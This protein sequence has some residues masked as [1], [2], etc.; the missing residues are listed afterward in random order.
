LRCQV[1]PS[2]PAADQTQNIII[3]VRHSVS[4]SSDSLVACLAGPDSHRVSLDGRLSA[5]GAHVFGVL[6]DLHLLYLFSKGGTVS[7]NRQI[8]QSAMRSNSFFKL[9]RVLWTLMARRNEEFAISRLE[10]TG[11]DSSSLERINHVP[12]TV[13]AGNSDLLGS[14]RHLG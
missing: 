1:Q 5:E 7:V 11:R 3:D 13:L 2:A 10:R 12:C 14:L 8:E 9:M 4:S 6:S